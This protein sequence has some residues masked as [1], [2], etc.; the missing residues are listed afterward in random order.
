LHHDVS[1]MLARRAALVASSSSPPAGAAASAT[2]RVVVLLVRELSLGR[3]FAADEQAALVTRLRDAA[4]LHG[5]PLVPFAGGVPFD[6]MVSL[7]ARAAAIVGIH[8]GE[9]ARPC[10]GALSACLGATVGRTPGCDLWPHAWC[11]SAACA[12]A[13]SQPD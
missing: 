13:L 9:S 3:A 11:D 1:A 7:F 12:C 10:A 5:L 6:D 4:K 2:G 8:G